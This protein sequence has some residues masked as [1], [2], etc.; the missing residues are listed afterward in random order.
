MT[1]RNS[2]FPLMKGCVEL[3]LGGSGHLTTRLQGAKKMFTFFITSRNSLPNVKMKALLYLFSVQEVMNYF[4]KKKKY[5]CY[6]NCWPS[7]HFSLPSAFHQMFCFCL[8][9]N[10]YVP[11]D[12]DLLPLHKSTSPP[13]SQPNRPYSL[14]MGT[15]CP[16]KLPLSVY[17]G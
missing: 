1:P 10:S 2:F 8:S 3:Y 14:L 5:P 7:F 15:Y 16:I 11:S 6:Q 17:T 9:P 4:Q 13:D 12:S